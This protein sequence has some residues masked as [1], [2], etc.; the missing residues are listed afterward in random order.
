MGHHKDGLTASC[1][2]F[3]ERKDY[4]G[5]HWIRCRIGTKAFCSAW[6]RNQHYKTI[7]CQCGRGC[8]LLDIMT[9]RGPKQ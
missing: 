4:K 2:H 1:P 5:G 3:Q 7:C 8:E 6:E 9:R